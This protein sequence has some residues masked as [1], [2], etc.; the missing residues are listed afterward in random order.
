[1]KPLILA[2][3]AFRTR[4]GHY[5]FLVKS[6]ELTNAPRVF[7]SL[8]NIIFTPYLY[9]FT[10]VFIDDIIVYSKSREDQ[11]KHLRTSL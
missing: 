6:F 1:M 11:A 2:K 3:I 9:Q 10:V 7:M 4:Y 5:E 8:M